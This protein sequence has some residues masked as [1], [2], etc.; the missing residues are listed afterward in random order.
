MIA[1]KKNNQWF[2]NLGRRF[3]QVVA[4]I[5]KLDI[6]SFVW[7]KLPHSLGAWPTPATFHTS[8]LTPVII[9]LNLLFFLSSNPSRHNMYGILF[10]FFFFE[11]LSFLLLFVSCF[12]AVSAAVNI[13]S[14]LYSSL[15]RCYWQTYDERRVLLLWFLGS[16]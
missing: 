15:I 11:I 12:V 13:H 6:A 1:L 7:S 2:N 9:Y 10:F 4:D 16:A 14:N 8:A 3:Q 5:W